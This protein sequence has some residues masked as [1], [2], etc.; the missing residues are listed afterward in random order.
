LQSAGVPEKSQDIIL[1]ELERMARRIVEQ[2][3]RVQ[4]R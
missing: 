1:P 3:G 2:E 4:A